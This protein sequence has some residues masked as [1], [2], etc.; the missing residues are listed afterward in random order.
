MNETLLNAL[1]SFMRATVENKKPDL[2][3]QD[4]L[5]LYEQLHKVAVNPIT[6]R[7]ELYQKKK[8]KED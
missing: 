6:K 4:A 1:F 5:E 2:N 3:K 8:K 7:V